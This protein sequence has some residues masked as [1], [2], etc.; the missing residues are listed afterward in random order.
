VKH[1]VELL[2]GPI[3]WF[4]SLCASFA[5]APWACSL[6]AK[7]VL[8]AVPVGAI[9]VAAFFAW[10]SWKHWRQ[11]G[12]EFPGE[13]SGSV[14][15]TRALTSGGVLLNATFAVVILAQLVAP[16]ILGACE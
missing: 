11:T 15:A 16:A 2:A 3:A 10:T 1:W 14:A 6:R 13:A 12:R 4:V 9:L 8:V 5:F 7:P